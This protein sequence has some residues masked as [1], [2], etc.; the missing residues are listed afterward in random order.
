LEGRANGTQEGKESTVHKK[1]KSQRYTRR[2]E[3]TVHQKGGV[4]GTSE[5]KSQRYTRRDTE[6]RLTTMY[7]R[8]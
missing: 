6:S 8:I 7:L 1:G 3:S 5:G 2:E 4:N